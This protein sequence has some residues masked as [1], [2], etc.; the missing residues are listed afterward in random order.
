MLPDCQQISRDIIIV[1]FV[2]GG[3][4]GAAGITAWDA[5]CRWAR[6]NFFLKWERCQDDLRVD[7]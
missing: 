3:I 2:G 1:A 5:L 4:L 6:K 7:V